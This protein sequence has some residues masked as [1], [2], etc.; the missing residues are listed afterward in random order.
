ME[1]HLAP[2]LAKMG[3]RMLAMM[4]RPEVAVATPTSDQRSAS[5]GKMQ[6]KAMGMKMVIA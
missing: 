1:T 6:K 2:A 3:A 5:S 4:K